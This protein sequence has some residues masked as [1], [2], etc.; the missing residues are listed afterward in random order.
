MDRAEKHWTAAK[1][2]LK[3]LN[4]EDRAAAE[5][6]VIQAEAKSRNAK[7]AITSMTPKQREKF[8]NKLADAKNGVVRANYALSMFSDDMLTAMDTRIADVE[9]PV[10][11]RHYE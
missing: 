9:I 5:E 10:I 1:E 2:T 8:G 7:I 4:P 3:T 6:A 11:T